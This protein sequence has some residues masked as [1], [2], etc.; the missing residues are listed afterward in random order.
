M[1]AKVTPDENDWE[2][3]RR[4]KARVKAIVK[5]EVDKTEYTERNGEV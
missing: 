2:E 4:Q 3:R 1:L 5:I